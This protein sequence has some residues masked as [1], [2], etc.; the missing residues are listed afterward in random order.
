MDVPCARRSVTSRQLVVT[1]FGCALIAVGVV[2]LLE[3]ELGVDPYTV[4]IDGIAAMFELPIGVALLTAGA[5]M[6]SAAWLLGRPPTAGLTMTI[7]LVAV[8]VSIVG[9]VAPT[10]S[11]LVGRTIVMIGAVVLVS[12]GVGVYRSV[13]WAEGPLDALPQALGDRL[14]RPTLMFAVVQAALLAIGWAMGGQIGI[15]T[16][17]SVVALGPIALRTEQLVKN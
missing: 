10:P 13:Q 9:G 4:F 7:G 3:A 8:V 6:T 14:G 12:I 15:G 1:A 11:S 5:V 2:G 16:V 17:V